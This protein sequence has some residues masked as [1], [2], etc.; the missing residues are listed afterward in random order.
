MKKYI[1]VSGT[2]DGHV[3][4]VVFF[5]LVV[6]IVSAHPC[7][8]LVFLDSQRKKYVPGPLVAKQGH[9]IHTGH[10][11]AWAVNHPYV[12]LQV[13]FLCYGNSGKHVLR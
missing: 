2:T 13:L 12:N 8:V 3:R 4:K 6:E 7:P 1:T 9:V 11:G 10:F 5:L